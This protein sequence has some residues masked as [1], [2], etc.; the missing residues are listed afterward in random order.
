MCSTDEYLNL[1]EQFQ[2]HLM[3][4]HTAHSWLAVSRES[5]WN[6]RTFASSIQKSAPKQEII[7]ESQKVPVQKI[8]V[9]KEPERNPVQKPVEIPKPAPKVSLTAPEPEKKIKTSPLEPA[10]P[11]ELDNFADIRKILSERFPEQVILP[12]PPDDSLAQTIKT[13]WK[14][15]TLN[16]VVSNAQPRHFSLLENICKAIQV[17]YGLKAEVIEKKLAGSKIKTSFIDMGDLDAYLREPKA[18]AHLWKVIAEKI[19]L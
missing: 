8:E 12:Q 18:K 7:H 19:K 10:A 3:Q 4:E 9:K 14:N 13:A 1:I 17:V 11:K 6:Y 16:L 2:L 5:Y 15:T